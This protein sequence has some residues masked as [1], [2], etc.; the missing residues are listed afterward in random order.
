M[1]IIKEMHRSKI[2]MAQVFEAI[3]NAKEEQAFAMLDELNTTDVAPPDEVFDM[4]KRHFP[5]DFDVEVF[6]KPFNEKVDLKLIRKGIRYANIY[7][8]TEKVDAATARTI[9]KK[10]LLQKEAEFNKITKAGDL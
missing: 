7:R 1:A 10:I 9:V 3:D 4:A 2:T 8:E 5:V 6:R